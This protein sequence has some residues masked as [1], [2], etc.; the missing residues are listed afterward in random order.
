MAT[1]KSTKSVITETVV[2]M[3]EADVRNAL[4]EYVAH[5][6]GHVPSPDEIEFIIRGEGLSDVWLEGAVWREK[7][8]ETS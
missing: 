2:E 7:E 5:Q 4:C 1:I 3:A 8:V 6:F